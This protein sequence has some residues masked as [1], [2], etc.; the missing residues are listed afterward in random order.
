VRSLRELLL[1]NTPPSSPQK[2]SP[3]TNSDESQRPSPAAA[4]PSSE[5]AIHKAAAAKQHADEVRARLLHQLGIRKSNHHHDP[6]D[7][8]TTSSSANSHSTAVDAA[9]TSTSDNN[10][11]N[12]SWGPSYTIALNDTHAFVPLS[13]KS[14]LFET[15]NNNNNNHNNKE[16]ENATTVSEKDAAAAA[17]AA[18]KND[19]EHSNDDDDDDNPQSILPRRRNLHFEE[20]VTVHPIPSYAV[21]SSRVR[22]TIWTD[23][24]ELAEQVARNSLEFSYEQWDAAQV[25]EEDQ[26]LRYQNE[27]IH[28]V[29]FA[30]G[31]HESQQESPERGLSS[32]DIWIQTCERLGIQPAEYYHSIHDDDNNNAKDSCNGDALSREE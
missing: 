25:V 32:D 11:N 12:K 15:N 1:Q 13:R 17:A 8:T 28:P 10:N 26:M 22:R 9:T 19:V 3:S 5:T 20:I 7:T 30:D 4:A 18:K 16:D 21:Y 6:R 14:H 31:D 27:W 23:G 29:H 2:K 24:A